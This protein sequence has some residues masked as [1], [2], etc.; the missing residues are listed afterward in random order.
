[1]K[2]CRKK[3]TQMDTAILKVMSIPRT[4]AASDV[5]EDNFDERVT[6]LLA[7]SSTTVTKEIF[8]YFQILLLNS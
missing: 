5:Q 2:G 1:M 4:I 3:I 8:W 7:D 6:L